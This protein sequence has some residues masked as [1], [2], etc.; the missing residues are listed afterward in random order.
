MTAQEITATPPISRTA[1]GSDV[2]TRKALKAKIA[3]P[4]QSVT[5]GGAPARREELAPAAFVA[6]IASTP[7]ADC[8]VFGHPYDASVHLPLL[9]TVTSRSFSRQRNDTIFPSTHM[10]VMIVSPG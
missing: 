5:V 7:S 10:S 1:V 4:R 3:T 6:C 8:D 2:D 9:I